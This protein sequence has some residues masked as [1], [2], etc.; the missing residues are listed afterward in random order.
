[1]AT[2]GEPTTES[3]F[4]ANKVSNWSPIKLPKEG[5]RHA[6]FISARDDERIHYL[7]IASADKIYDSSVGRGSGDL[8]ATSWTTAARPG[9]GSESLA[10][11]F[12]DSYD[13]RSVSPRPCPSTSAG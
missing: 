1:M 7:A 11:T 13:T 9:I 3:S 10:Q 6:E 5:A 8:A 12:D 4:Y 2:I